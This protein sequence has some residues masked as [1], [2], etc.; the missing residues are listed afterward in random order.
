M[1]ESLGHLVVRRKRLTLVLFVI[2]LV[3]AGALGAGAFSRLQAAGYDNPNSDSARAAQLLQDRFGVTDP[4]LVVAI[5]ADAG[6]DSPAAAAAGE[7][8]GRRLAA[9]Q[10]VTAVISYWNA[11]RPAQL[12]SPDGTAAQLFVYT[13]LPESDQADLATRIVDTYSGDRDG[14]TVHVGGGAAVNAALNEQV[15]EDLKRAEAIAVPLTVVLLVLVFGSIVAAG[16]PFIVAAG[17]IVGTFATLYLITLATDVSVFALNLITGLGLGLGIDYALLVVNRFREELARLDDVDAA[18]VRTVA[19]AGRTVFVSGLTVAV[20]LAALLA[21]PQYFLQSFGYAGIAVTLLAVVST[22]VALPA[23]LALI[24]HRVNRFKVRRGTLTPSDTGMWATVARR[25]MRSP[26]PVVLVVGAI[27]LAV[28]SPARDAVFGQV[29]DRALPADAPVAVAGQVLREQ[30]PGREGTPV[31]VIVPDGAADPAA[32]AAVQ[33]YAERLAAV[34]DVVRVD[35]PAD[36]DGA[37]FVAGADARLSVVADVDPRS[38]QGQQLVEDLRAVPAPQGTVIGGVAATYADSQDGITD[39]L[40]VVLLWIALTTLIVLFLFTGSVLLPVKAIALNLLSLGATLGALVWVFQNGNLGW[41]V[42]D[43][44]VTGTV[45]TSMI[46]LIAIVAFALSMDYEVFLLSRIKEEHDRGLD[47]TE[48][49]ALGLQ[50][51]GRIITAAAAL[52]AIVFASFV[53]SGVTNIKQLGLGVAFAIV[54]DA[55]VVRGLLV[56]ALMQIM[57]RANWWAPAPLRALHRRFGLSEGDPLPDAPA[58]ADEPA[59]AGPRH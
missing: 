36:P 47:T 51:S 4:A 34:A 53:S 8:L 50:R 13:D 21:F 42:G 44:T 10:D 12:K 1:F 31:N 26:W 22:L 38:P 56:P 45:D 58:A 14:L 24:G 59:L 57:G 37:R 11:G 29:D 48:A 33:D 16:L 9:E 2:G 41:L 54:I 3:L 18:V 19:T 7:D 23:V 40:P 55:T 35:S 30:F 6:V 5:E 15:G 32:L 52:L 46:V 17:A 20:T 27:M 28:A 43:F 49:V 25:V 39:R